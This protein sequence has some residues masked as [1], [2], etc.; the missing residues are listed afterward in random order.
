M[1]KKADLIYTLN[2]YRSRLPLVAFPM[3]LGINLKDNLQYLDFLTRLLMESDRDEI[4]LND[5]S[6]LQMYMQAVNVLNAVSEL[7]NYGKDKESLEAIKKWYKKKFH[8]PLQGIIFVEDVYELVNKWREKEKYIKI[9]DEFEIEAYESVLPYLQKFKSLSRE[10]QIEVQNKMQML[11]KIKSPKTLF[12]K[13]KIM[14]NNGLV[15]MVNKI[16][17]EQ[18][19]KEEYI[20]HV[21]INLY[22]DFQKGDSYMAKSFVSINNWLTSGI[23]D[24][25]QIGRAHV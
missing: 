13:A 14:A 12:E 23:D 9:P 11:E 17:A 1:I 25:Y 10:K 24:K 21:F 5:Y 22:F 19:D 8:I 6:E 2:N 15:A 16:N 4:K 18:A 7:P 20:G 3:S